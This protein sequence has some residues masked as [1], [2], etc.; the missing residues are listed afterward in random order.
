MRPVQNLLIDSP[1]MREAIRTYVHTFD[2]SNHA[3]WFQL[4]IRLQMIW[5]VIGI[6]NT[7]AETFFRGVPHFAFGITW[8]GRVFIAT[9]IPADDA[10]SSEMI[11]ASLCFDLDRVQDCDVGQTWSA[12]G[13][14]LQ[15]RR[16]RLGLFA[17]RRVS[18]ASRAEDEPVLA[19]P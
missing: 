15:V 2:I 7:D 11:P 4:F 10:G 3:G 8:Y 1:D 13:Q 17:L 12:F 19:P 14:S 9:Y 6:I 16:A 18:A 5:I